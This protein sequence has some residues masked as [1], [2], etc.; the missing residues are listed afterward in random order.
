LNEADK[1]EA[2]KE[3]DPQ[4]ASMA[5]AIGTDQNIIAALSQAFFAIAIEFGSGVGFW[6]VFGH[7]GPPGRRVE[8]ERVAADQPQKLIPVEE[9]PADIVER[10]PWCISLNALIILQ[11]CEAVLCVGLYVIRKPYEPTSQI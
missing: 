1:K 2:V 7:A 8:M 3:A 11:I 5:N 6:L 9:K 10:V 4:S